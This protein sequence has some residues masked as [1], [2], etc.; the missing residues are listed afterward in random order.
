MTI[1]EAGKKGRGVFAV[2]PIQ[3]GTVIDISP[4][5]VFSQEEYE[6]H[7]RHTVVDHYTYQW[8]NGH[9]ALALGLGSLFNHSQTPNVGFIRDSLA[10]CIRYITLS[11]I[12]PGDE[13]SI[14]YGSASKLWFQNE[15]DQQ[16]QQLKHENNASSDSET[17][18]NVFSKLSLEDDD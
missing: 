3:K 4:V 7:A 15:E 6:K 2:V 11:D 17:E 1:K 5:L 13:L 12:A 18:E 9:M 8:T 14:S 16:Q 10:L